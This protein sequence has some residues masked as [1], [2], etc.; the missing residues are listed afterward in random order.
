MDRR[1]GSGH[2]PPAPG[3]ELVAKRDRFSSTFATEEPGKFRKVVS[4]GP[5][6]YR[7]GNGWGAIDTR[8][9]RRKAGKLSIAANDFGLEIAEQPSEQQLVKM[10]RKG[11]SVAWGLVGVRRPSS[12]SRVENKVSLREILPEVDMELS[13]LADG[14]K[15]D[16][17]LRST[18]AQRV[19]TFPLTLSGLS[20]KVD[21]AGDL[22][23]TDAAGAEAGRTPAGWMQDS[24][25]DPAGQAGG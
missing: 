23:F 11:T 14:L 3:E 25:A 13:S 6:H 18:A 12:V 21:E 15:E 10:D 5:V 19:F 4:S 24:S 7:E 20:A 17:I 2:A 22:V 1:S 9:V 8:L 16:L